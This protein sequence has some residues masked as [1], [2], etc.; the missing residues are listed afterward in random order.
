MLGYRESRSTVTPAIRIPTV[1]HLKKN[2]LFLPYFTRK[3]ES[4]IF[5]F[6]WKGTK[7]H[8]TIG[9]LG[10]TPGCG[11]THLAI[12][13]GSYCSS[14]SK[15]STAFLE[16][17]PRDEISRLLPGTKAVDPEESSTV[18][19]HFKLQ[20]IDY[21]PQVK[22]DEIPA[23]LN[24]KYDYLI[25]DMGSLGE[26]DLSE[27]LRCDR[28]L[29]LGSLAPWKTESYHAF[30]DKFS[31]TYNLGEGFTYL[32]QTGNE[33]NAREFSKIHHVS[34]RGVPFIQNPFRIEKQLF[35]FLEGLL[36]EH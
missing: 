24:L 30:F 35:L 28:K 36:T 26:A 31:S 4:D 13:L 33:K 3:E 6:D 15:K 17:H 22:S 20:G 9:I 10:C 21:Y 19:P 18:R 11:V 25:L 34:M 12:A 14:K 8:A 29:V 1:F 2:G 5:G 32:M 23:L 16:L 7:S 27:F